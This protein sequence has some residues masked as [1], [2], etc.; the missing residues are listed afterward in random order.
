MIQTKSKDSVILKKGILL[1]E[2]SDNYSEVR[3]IV[4]K[5]TN[6][7][8]GKAL[9]EISKEDYHVKP[10]RYAGP[11]YAKVRLAY[12]QKNYP[13]LYERMKG[14]AKAYG[15]SLDSTD[16]DFSVCHMIQDLLAAR[17]STSPICNL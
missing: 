4:L 8:I 16:L 12:M 6:E 11:I 3:H 9:G 15:V 2:D 17:W 10:S 13:A 7:E 14:A 1:K 5:G